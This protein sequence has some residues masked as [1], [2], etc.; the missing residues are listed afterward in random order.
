MNYRKLLFFFALIIFT[1]VIVSKND[2]VDSDSLGTL[3]TSQ[4]IIEHKTIKLDNYN[5]TSK[6]YFYQICK[7]NENYYYYFPLGSSVSSIPFVFIATKIFSLNMNDKDD[8]AKVQKIIAGI[9][10]A[11]IFLFLFKIAAF[12]FSSNISVYLAFVFWLSTSL[13]STLGTGL[14]SQNFATL[15]SAI[16]IYLTLYII[17]DKN[18]ETWFIL[19]LVLFLAY[20]TRPTMSL[21]SIFIVLFLFFNHK[22]AIA[23]KTA[24]VVSALLGVF[25]LF[26]IYEYKQLLPDYYMPKRLDSNTFYLALYGNLFSPSRGLFIYSPFLLLFLFNID[27]FYIILKKNKTLL[28]FL[29]WIILHL[30]VISKFPHWWAGASF[31][32]RFMVDVLIPIYILFLILLYEITKDKNSLRYKLT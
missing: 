32:P 20:L 15:Y 27:K 4:S 14:W 6:R 26:S 11:L 5:L 19:G 16:A 3:L 10:S 12:Y 22:R 13:S 9:I 17:K 23:M 31:G 24:L 25:V 2:T 21:L 28:F 8:D 1:I 29:T 30:I 18:K 7:K